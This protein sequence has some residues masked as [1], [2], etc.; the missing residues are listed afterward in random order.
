VYADIREGSSGRV[1]QTT[2]RL[3]LMTIC[4]NLCGYFFGN[5]GD[6]ANNIIL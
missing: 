1:R 5:F 4:G 2:V 6:K 3:T